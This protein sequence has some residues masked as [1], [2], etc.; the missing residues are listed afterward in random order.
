M[1]TK[2]TQIA[3]FAVAA[4][5]IAGFNIIPAYADTVA[6]DQVIVPSSGTGYAMDSPGCGTGDDCKLEIRANGFND[7]VELTIDVQGST[8]CDRVDYSVFVS[9]DNSG[10]WPVY[11][12]IYNA[13]GVYL[14]PINGQLDTGDKVTAV[15]QFIGCS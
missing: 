4:F 2:I 15:A 11:G 1:T 8:E 5:A 7:E 3:M 6:S 9:P 14:V 13:D 12:Q 10:D